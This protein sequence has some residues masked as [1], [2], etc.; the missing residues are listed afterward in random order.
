MN[1][2]GNTI[3][4]YSSFFFFMR[5]I[6]SELTSVANLLLF[7]HVGCHHSLPWQGLVYVYTRDP[8]LWT[9]AAKLARTRLNHYAMGLAPIFFWEEKYMQFSDTLTVSSNILDC[10]CLL[11]VLQRP[12][13]GFLNSFPS[14]RSY[15]LW[16]KEFRERVTTFIF[17]IVD[18]LKLLSCARLHLILQHS[19]WPQLLEG[20]A[21]FRVLWGLEDSSLPAARSERGQGR[22]DPPP[23]TNPVLQGKQI[24]FSWPPSETL[25][26]PV[27]KVLKVHRIVKLNVI[28]RMVGNRWRNVLLLRRCTLKKSGVNFTRCAPS[29]QMA[30]QK[31]CV[32]VCV[33]VWERANVTKNPNCYV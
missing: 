22:L 24:L 7:L 4:I 1:L 8:N 25:H 12:L 3:T 2:E 16:E 17:I 29:F 14:P 9:R 11:R 27:R 6:R 23:W 32:C 33:F 26:K 31:V 13:V 18:N 28:L 15:F 21:V 10:R 5:K 19:P 20:Q 30:H